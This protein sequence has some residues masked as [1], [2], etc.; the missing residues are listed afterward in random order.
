MHIDYLQNDGAGRTVLKA[1]RGGD[2]RVPAVD[3]LI[4]DAPPKNFHQDRLA[5]AGV[6]LFGGDAESEI[7]FPWEISYELAEAV[8]DV[9]GL[10]VISEIARPKHLMERP[11]SGE[12]A[13]LQVTTLSI[14]PVTGFSERTPEVDQTRLG[15]VPGERFQGALFGIKEAIIS[16]NAWLLARA[17]EPATVLLAAGVLYSE[18]FLAR[19]LRIELADG[20]AAQVSTPA[21]QLCAAVGLDVS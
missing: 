8:R 12:G 6:L 7:S 18:D 16:S 9:R 15:L 14:Q 4:F 19:A 20:S 3:R 10:Q 21:R 13:P 5:V 17:T 2:D 1:V 11:D